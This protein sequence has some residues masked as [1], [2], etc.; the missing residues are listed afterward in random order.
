MFEIDAIGNSVP[1]L[2]GSGDQ[3][4]TNDWEDTERAYTE[5]SSIPDV[6]GSVAN[7]FSYKGISLNVLITYGIGGTFF[8]TGHIWH[9]RL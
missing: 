1:V 9:Q 4:T 7:S 2:D 3:E 8:R 5:D 6:L